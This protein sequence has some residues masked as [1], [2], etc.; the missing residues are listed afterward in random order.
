LK[1]PL[2][3]RALSH[4]LIESAFGA[5]LLLQVVILDS[6]AT[7]HTIR[8]GKEP[9]GLDRCRCLA[10]EHLKQLKCLGGEAQPAEDAEDPDELI[11]EDQRV[12]RE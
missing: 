10:R 12:P 11:A 6:E 5:D 2:D 4:N 8:V 3:G 1:N 9:G 7:R